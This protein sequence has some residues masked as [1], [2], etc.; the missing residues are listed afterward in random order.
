MQPWKVLFNTATRNSWP[1]TLQPT[2]ARFCPPQGS[3]WIISI[4]HT[5]K[6]W[7]TYLATNLSSSKDHQMIIYQTMTSWAIIP[8]HRYC[9]NKRSWQCLAKKGINED[10]MFGEIRRISTLRKLECS[11]CHLYLRTWFWKIITRDVYTQTLVASR[12]IVCKHQWK[13][14][15]HY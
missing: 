12:I 13:W 3:C 8:D 5:T 1:I 14:P 11:L 10:N 9:G 15:L 2:E 6:C 7:Q 4:S